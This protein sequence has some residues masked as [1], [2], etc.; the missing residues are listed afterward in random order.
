LTI[1][2]FADGTAKSATLYGTPEE[3]E[4]FSRMMNEAKAAALHVEQRL[5]RRAQDAEGLA[6]RNERFA[7]KLFK[8]W[9]SAL[10]RLGTDATY[11]TAKS[12]FRAQC[13]AWNAHSMSQHLMRQLIQ[14]PGPSH[15]IRVHTEETCRAQ[16]AAWEANLKMQ[17]ER[18]AWLRA[19]KRKRKGG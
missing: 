10:K 2:D 17:R 9:A 4:A 14:W 11:G 5:H 13:V 6:A 12:V 15:A 7:W 19:E 1:V 18:D 3:V 16:R 8:W